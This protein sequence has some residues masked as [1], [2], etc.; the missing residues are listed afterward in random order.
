MSTSQ[1]KF[2]YKVLMADSIFP[3]QSIEKEI[4]ASIGAELVLAPEQTETT[5]SHLAEDADAILVTYA[6]I[7]KAVIDSCRKCKIIARTGIGYNNVDLAAASQQGIVVTNVPDYCI[8]EVADHTLALILTCLRKTACLTAQVQRGVWDMNKARPIHRL[9]SLSV[10][11]AGF[12]NIAQAVNKR[13]QAFGFTVKAYDPYLPEEVFQ[14]ARV[15]R[16]ASMTDL[17]QGVDVLSLHMPLTDKTKHVINKELLLHMPSSA[18]L[19]NS[20]RGQLINEIDLAQALRDGVIAGCGLDV[21]EKEPLD[22]AS[23]LL[24]LDNVCLTP[25][26]AFYSEESDL[27]LRQKATRQII[28]VLSGGQ[29]DYPVNQKQIKQ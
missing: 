23:P 12:G 27:E 14:D 28:K 3:D 18:I 11:L 10:G 29:A 6:E 2:T 1:N 24:V 26:V 22:P 25:H 13:L 9:S 4:L 5:L 15:E 19:I 21:M 7:S 20:S 8:D 17:A 16:I